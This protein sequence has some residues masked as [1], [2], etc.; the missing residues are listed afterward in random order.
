MLIIPLQQ[1]FLKQYLLHETKQNIYGSIFLA[2]NISF[3][4]SGDGLAGISTLDRVGTSSPGRGSRS[5][6]L[7]SVLIELL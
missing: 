7:G 2:G 3:P 6:F 1:Q 5:C 4:V